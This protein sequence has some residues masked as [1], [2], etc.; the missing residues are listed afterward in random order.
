MSQNPFLLEPGDVADL[1]E[2]GIDNG[3]LRPHELIIIQISDQFH[4]SLP[5]IG[6]PG[7]QLI[8]ALCRTLASHFLNR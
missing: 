4:G 8:A 7:D 6:N 1:P 5:G 2:Q 3:H